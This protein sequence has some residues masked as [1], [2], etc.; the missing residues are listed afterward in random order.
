MKKLAIALLLIPA[1]SFAQ[2]E[3]TQTGKVELGTSGK[4]FFIKDGEGYKLGQ[5]KQVFTNQEA[6]NHIKKARTNKTFAEIITYTGSFGIGFG[7]GMALSVKDNELF[8]GQVKRDRNTGWAI[9]GIGAGVA[10]TSIPLWMGYS[11]NIRKG[12]KVENG[13][14]ENSVSQLKLNVNGN[15]VGMAYQF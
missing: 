2:V 5:Y 12:I 4:N 15:G 6:I 14:N 9:A 1:L 8:E 13:T 10:L 7:I 3:E 11:K